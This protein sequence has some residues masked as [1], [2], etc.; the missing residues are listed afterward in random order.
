MQLYTDAT[1]K[2]LSCELK[3]VYINKTLANGKNYDEAFMYYYFSECI[4]ANLEVCL[5]LEIKQP[6]YGRNN[7]QISLNRQI[8]VNAANWTDSSIQKQTFGNCLTCQNDEELFELNFVTD[9]HFPDQFSWELVDSNHSIIANGGHHKEKQTFFHY[10]TCIS[11]NRNECLTLRLFD[12]SGSG[13]TFYVAILD[14]SII[15]E[16]NHT[17]AMD[18]IKIGKC[19]IS[20]PMNYNF[21][22]LDLL[23]SDHPEDI[24]W[25]LTDSNDTILALRNKFTSTKMHHYYGKCILVPHNECTTLRLFDNGML[26]GG[27]R[28]KISVGSTNYIVSWDGVIVDGNRMVGNSHE[29]MIN[30]CPENQTRFELDFVTDY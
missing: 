11:Q 15:V 10:G 19:S 5:E 9:N 24:S 29:I 28:R 18:K 4:P 8:I 27:G 21:F 22:E 1:V 7:F 30:C 6:S 17:V 25:E 12:T 3:D 2:E 20:C 14:G 23:I 16:Q 26:N 13:N